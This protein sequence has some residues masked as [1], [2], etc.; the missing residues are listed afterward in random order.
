MK[1]DI[2]HRRRI[3]MV[4]MEFQ[5]DFIIKFCAI[6]VFAAL[7]LAGIVYAL[8]TKSTTAV[9]E[10]SRLIIKSTADFLL[11]LLLLSSLVAIIATGTLTIIFTLII[12]HRIAGPLYRLEKDIAEVNNG[13][14]N[15]EI[16]V[17][18]DDELQDLAKSLNQMLKLINNTVSV[19]SKEIINIPATSLPEKDQQHLENAKNILKKFKC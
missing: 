17:R 11:P 7:I 9:F 6:I 3:H 12:S 8:S 18:K 13:N 19:V 16:R 1:N 10:N 5:R 2:R 14:L 4:K 15:M